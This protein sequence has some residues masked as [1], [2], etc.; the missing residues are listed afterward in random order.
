MISRVE[1]IRYNHPN[2]TKTYTRD[3]VHRS[4]DG[5]CCLAFDLFLQQLENQLNHNESVLWDCDWEKVSFLCFLSYLLVKE[6]NWVIKCCWLQVCGQCISF[7]LLLLIVVA[8]H[9]HN[10][11][12]RFS[13]AGQ[14]KLKLKTKVHNRQ[15]FSCSLHS[16]KYGIF[17]RMQF[18]QLQHPNEQKTTLPTAQQH[19]KSKCNS[20]SFFGVW[21]IRD[22]ALLWFYS[23]FLSSTTVWRMFHFTALNHWKKMKKN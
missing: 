8:K 13:F 16:T 12:W 19:I 1:H 20:L 22:G 18:A 4:I 7:F 17:L 23:V 9:R 2:A 3:T 15:F 21:L 5:P 11:T 6:L 10:Y 14:I